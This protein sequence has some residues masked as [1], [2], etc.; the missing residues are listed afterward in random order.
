M[1]DIET[2][3]I[4]EF[5]KNDVGALVMCTG[6]HNAGRVGKIVHKEKHKVGRLSAAAR[7]AQPRQQACVAVTSD[8]T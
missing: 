5:V 7:F 2:G 8:P 3:K 4:K 1:L 6:G